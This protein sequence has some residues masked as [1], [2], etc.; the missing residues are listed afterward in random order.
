VFL[1]N[2]VLAMLCIPDE[3]DGVAGDRLVRPYFGM[4]RFEWS[5]D[6]SIEF[7]LPHGELI[8][9]LRRCGFEIEGLTEVRPGE[10]ATT[11]Y[12]FVPLEWA[13]KWPVEEVWKARKR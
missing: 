1:V 5:D 8:A 7:H 10:H 3:E 6:D 13:R 11:R 2:G 4:H 12:P 9:L